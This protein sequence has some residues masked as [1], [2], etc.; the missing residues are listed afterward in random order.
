MAT[1]TQTATDTLRE[2]ATEVNE[3]LQQTAERARS[4]IE[5][6]FRRADEVTRRMVAEYPLTTLVGAVAAGYVVGR[7]LATRR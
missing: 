5:P 7:I 2:R 6:M 3:A 1:A 4:E